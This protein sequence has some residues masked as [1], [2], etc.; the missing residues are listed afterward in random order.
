[1]EW[2]ADAPKRGDMIRTKVR[3]YHHYGIFVDENC[4]V[5][6]G[7]PD[8]TGVDPDTIAVLT[9]DMDTF[10]HGG[11]PETARL[12]AAERK[13]RRSPERTVEYAL[14]KVGTTGYNIL[15]NN[16][17]HFA[18]E[19]LFGEAKSSFLDDVREKIRIKKERKG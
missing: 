12:S 6:F 4:V 10:M 5:Q 19:C 13:K 2:T 7:L 14:S 16:C 18:N 11:I 8:N 9:T 3:F 1:M 17:E 15:H